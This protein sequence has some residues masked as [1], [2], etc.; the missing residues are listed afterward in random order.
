MIYMLFSCGTS[1]K[2]SLQYCLSFFPKEFRRILMILFLWLFYLNLLEIGICYCMFIFNI[3]YC[4]LPDTF[5][6]NLLFASPFVFICLFFYITYRFF[7]RSLNNYMAP[8]RS[9]HNLFINH[10]SRQIYMSRVCGLVIPSEST[11]YYP[12]INVADTHTHV[13]L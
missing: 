9:L 7:K 1:E 6:L 11:F 13:L 12:T 5:I 2:K 10:F 8:F 4:M 3:I